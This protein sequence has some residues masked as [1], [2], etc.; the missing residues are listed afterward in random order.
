MKFT[1]GNWLVREGYQIHFPRIVHEVEERDGGR[2]LI[3]TV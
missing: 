1:N 3:C 2:H